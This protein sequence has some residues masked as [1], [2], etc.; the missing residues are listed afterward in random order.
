MGEI[1]IKLIDRANCQLASTIHVCDMS[2]NKPQPN[3]I[4]YQL[5]GFFRTQTGKRHLN[6]DP[7]DVIGQSFSSTREHF[8]FESLHINF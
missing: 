2:Q 3:K 4:V 7:I 8:W 5:H 6:H 1:N